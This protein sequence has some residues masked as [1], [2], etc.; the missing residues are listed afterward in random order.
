MTGP[1]SIVST[2]GEEVSP[3]PFDA[4]FQSGQILQRVEAALTGEAQPIASERNIGEADAMCRG[5]FLVELVTILLA[6]RYQVT[7]DAGEVAGDALA[8]LDLLDEIDGAGMRPR[9]DARVVLAANRDQMMPAVVEC[10]R[11]V[12][13]GPA[14]HAAARRAGIEHDHPMAV[15]RQQVGRGHAAKSRPHDRYIGVDVLGERRR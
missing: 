2:R 6:R 9:G 13:R 11:Q 8:S 10:R 5:Q 3:C 15:A 7:L 14:G 1:S 4:A 12:R